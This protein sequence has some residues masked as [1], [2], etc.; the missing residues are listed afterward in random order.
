MTKKLKFNPSIHQIKLNPEQG[1]LHCAAY[2][3]TWTIGS[4]YTHHPPTLGGCDTDDFGD[5]I[6]IPI[7][8]SYNIGLWSEG[9]KSS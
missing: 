9:S 3:W 5:K 8:T 2:G 1:V 4:T 6:Q 7:P